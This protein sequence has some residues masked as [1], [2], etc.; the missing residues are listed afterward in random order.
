MKVI[1]FQM[2][3]LLEDPILCP[4]ILLIK[5]IFYINYFKSQK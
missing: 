4:A 1:N 2:P 5:I 3:V